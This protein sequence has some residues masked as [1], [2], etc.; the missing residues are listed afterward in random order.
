MRSAL[1][2]HSVEFT[3]PFHDTDAMQVVWHGN[4]LKYFEITKDALFAAL[5]VDL[6]AFF[7]KTGFLFPVIR[8]TTKH[9]HPL[10]YNDR[11][12]CTA[13]MVECRRKITVE[14][15]IRLVGDDTLCAKGTCEQVAIR[16]EDFR[17]QLSIPEEIRR[18]LGGE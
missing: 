4:Y 8:T 12:R 2:Q 17:L 11:F 16:T 5:G 18:V 7:T 10:R 15:E 13:S 6:V 1:S 14:F 9:I 3:V